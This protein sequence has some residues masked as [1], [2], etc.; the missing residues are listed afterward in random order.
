VLDAL[1]AKLLTLASDFSILLDHSTLTPGENWRPAINVWCGMCDAAILLVT[2]DSI[3]ADYCVYEWSVLA[4]RMAMSSKFRL[5]PLYLGTTPEAL[6]GKPQ[7]IA[8][9]QGIPGITLSSIEAIWPAIRTWLDSITSNDGPTLK[10]AQ[11]IG[12]MCRKAI[13]DPS[14]NL[15][16]HALAKVD[17]HLGTWQPLVD[18][19]DWFALKLIGIGL[20][21]AAPALN[22][23][24][25]AFDGKD[26]RNIVGLVLGSWVADSSAQKLAE[27]SSGECAKRSVAL[28]LEKGDTARLYVVK[29][30]GRP[31]SNTW[32]S[33]DVVDVGAGFDDLKIQVTRSLQHALQLD[34]PSL[35]EKTL[36]RK[37]KLKE[38]VVVYLP[39]R[40]LDAAWLGE[41]RRLFQNVTFFLL[42]GTDRLEIDG[43]E[44]MVPELPDGFESAFWAENEEIRDDLYEQ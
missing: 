43:V 38:P 11:Q 25:W 35:I 27:R 2:P 3:H 33:A 24:R 26:W 40:S 30:S 15:S 5:L 31:P 23:I 39:S 20:C 32:P 22:D 34:D 28:N 21:K 10:Q 41:L 36:R 12:T 16:T 4:Y 14:N 17:L 8:E 37:E 1:E 29:A 9:I 18:P 42:A 19:W 7:Q 13:P 6:R 44:W